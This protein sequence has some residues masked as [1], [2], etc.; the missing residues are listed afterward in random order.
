MGIVRSLIGKPDGN[1]PFANTNSRSKENIET[2]F[3][4]IMWDGADWIN[5]AQGRRTVVNM[6]IS[7]RVPQNA[8]NS[9]H[10]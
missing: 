8:G 5:L 10:S 7:L 3:E 4:E 2:C 9:L 1:R 6:G